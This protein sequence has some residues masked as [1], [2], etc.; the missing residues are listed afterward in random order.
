MPS[1]STGSA[2]LAQLLAA[3]GVDVVTG[4]LDASFGD[5]AVALDDHGVRR[6]APSTETA[7]VHMA[8]A[9]SHLTGRPGVALLASASGLAHA[10]PAIADAQQSGDRVL[11]ISS[12]RRTGVTGPNRDGIVAGLDNAAVTSSLVKWSARVPSGHRL[13]ELGGAAMRALWQGGPGVVHLDV[14]TSVLTGP[15]RR[16]DPPVRSVLE[17]SDWWRT[18]G[19]PGAAAAAVGMLIRARL[20][21]LHLGRGVLHSQAEDQVRRLVATLDAGVTTTWGARGVIAEDDLHVIPPTHPGV[22]DDLRNDADVVMVLGTD[23]GESDWW[24]QPPHWGTAQDQAIIQVDIDA[25]AIGRS[26]A[27]DL[28][29]VGDIA[30]VLDEVLD[31]LDALEPRDTVP[32]RHMLGDLRSAVRRGRAN[33]N[34]PLVEADRTPI[35][36]AAAVVA[37]RLAMPDD[38]LW[39][40]DGGHTRRWGQF[41]IPAMHPRAQFGVGSLELTGGGVGQAMG[42]RLAAPDRMV[43]AIM[44]DGAFARQLGELPTSL[45]HDLPF[46]AVVLVDGY[47]GPVDATAGS[48]RGLDR[49]ADPD[50]TAGF[51]DDEHA[52][53]DGAGND[54]AGNGTG[55]AATT[56][57]PPQERRHVDARADDEVA[58]ELAQVAM[59][60]APR[61]STGPRVR[62]RTKWP[63]AGRCRR[64]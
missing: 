11:V 51:D 30:T 43:C 22:V 31:Q 37:T 26:R 8:A 44:G 62:Q 40:F 61:P 6:V 17:D 4:V 63:A 16:P 3:H 35:H 19:R 48:D 29:I 10:L 14:P 58:D 45:E 25:A 42:A 50:G 36:P 34:E 5:L 28:A 20:P 49:L 52:A 18:A 27:V 7:A 60:P 53:V 33:L 32:R 64:T 24:G 21:V 39:V 9:W 46:V 1:T 41:H 59:L 2:V 38:T 23:L 15:A 54:G 47:A 56:T 13:A 55:P 12:S 57:V